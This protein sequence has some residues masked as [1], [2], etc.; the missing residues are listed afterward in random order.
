MAQASNVIPLQ[1]K[2]NSPHPDA[3]LIAACVAYGFVMGGA[4]AGWRIDPTDSDF[5]GPAD[6]R[7]LRKG[8][9]LIEKMKGLETKTLDGIAAKA[10]V[11]ELICSSGSNYVSPD[12]V[13]FTSSLAK[14]I[15]NFQLSAAGETSAVA[16]TQQ[17]KKIS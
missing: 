6:I 4:A 10:G 2:A 8:E 7:N 12:E 9:A 11:V 15:M 16:I 5:A 17:R 14:D 1:K 13:E 3:Q